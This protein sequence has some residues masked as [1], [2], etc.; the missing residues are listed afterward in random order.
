MP[1]TDT[2]TFTKHGKVHTRL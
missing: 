1:D 2:D